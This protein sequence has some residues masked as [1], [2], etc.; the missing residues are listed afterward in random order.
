MMTF[1]VIFCRRTNQSTPEILAPAV[2]NPD[3]HA[4]DPRTRD[5]RTRGPGIWG[6]SVLRAVLHCYKYNYIGYQCQCYK[7]NLQLYLVRGRIDNSYSTDVRTVLSMVVAM[8]T[9]GVIHSRQHYFSDFFWV[10]VVYSTVNWESLETVCIWPLTHGP[11]QC[12]H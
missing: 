1:L 9:E 8:H 5:P 4:L 11:P 3:I 7:R 6:L 10:R 12:E 2:W